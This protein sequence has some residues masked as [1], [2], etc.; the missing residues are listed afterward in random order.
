M[1]SSR[2][3]ALFVFALLIVY[4]LVFEKKSGWKEK[5]LIYGM[6]FLEGMVGGF[7]IDCIGINAG[8]YYFPRQSFLSWQYFAVVVPC[9]GVFGLFVNCLWSWL[10][11]EKF[12]RGMVAT[13]IPLFLWYEGTNIFTHSWTYAVSFPY[14]MAGWVPLIWTFAG[15]RRRRRVVWKIE[16]WRDSFQGELLGNKLIYVFLTIV[17]ALLIFVMFPL[18]LAIAVRLCIE[19]P[20]LLKRHVPIWTYT[21]YLLAME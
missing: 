6:A 20:S 11:R 21:K 10:G 18:F 13:L 16:S 14:V 7:I 8:Y 5:L 17:K 12:W 2:W 3:L 15:C 9:W 4:I 19:L 1:I